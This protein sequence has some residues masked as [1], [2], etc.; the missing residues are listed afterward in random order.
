MQE[1]SANTADVTFLVEAWARGDDEAFEQL[2]P[3]VY[4]Q[5]NQSARMLLSRESSDHTL[6][7]TELVHEVCLRLWDF[8][9]AQA[10][11]N[12][13]QFRRLAITA[14]RRLLVDHARQ[15]AAE[16][17]GGQVQRAPWT[18][19]LMVT[20]GQRLNPYN[21]VDLHRAMEQLREL[22]PLGHDVVELRFWGGLTYDEIADVLDTSREAVRSKW[23][24]CR[25]LLLRLMPT[26][27]A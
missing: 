4:R 1:P 27:D 19:A 20:L 9:P 11:S 7:P 2:L 22:D 24:A 18:E 5:L 6:E 13:H 23:R 17:R 8:V 26:A 25:P 16:Y 21:L 10:P 3:H 14:M 15:K 12:R